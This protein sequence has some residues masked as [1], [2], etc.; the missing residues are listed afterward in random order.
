MAGGEIK[1]LMAGLQPGVSNC[2]V[3]TG[4]LVKCEYH[5]NNQY[6]FKDL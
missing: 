1:V 4:C 3:D 6:C 5:I 2:P